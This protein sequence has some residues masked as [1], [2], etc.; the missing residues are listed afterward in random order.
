MSC[1]MKLMSCQ[2]VLKNT[3]PML[4]AFRSVMEIIKMRIQQDSE[5]ML[6][7]NL[8]LS[9]A[10]QEIVSLNEKGIIANCYLIVTNCRHD[11]C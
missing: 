11:C 3:Q 5:T 7:D 1:R 4:P 8:K 9:T 10:V 2:A 6:T